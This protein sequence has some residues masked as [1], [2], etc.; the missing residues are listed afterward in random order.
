[1]KPKTIFVFGASRGIGRVFAQRMAQKG[2]SVYV[3]ARSWEPRAKLE[4]HFIKTDLSSSKN[5]HKSLDAALAQ[6][7]KVDALVFA[8]K[9]RDKDTK[10]KRRMQ[11]ELGSTKEIIEL[12][13]D[14]MKQGG[15]IVAISSNAARVVAPEQPPS[16]HAAK[17]ALEQLV[18]YY[19]LKLAPKGIRVNGV[20]PAI[21]L[22]PENRA[23]Y[24]KNK[25]IKERFAQAIALGR[26]CEAEDV[27]NVIEF[28]IGKKSSFITGQ[29]ITVDGGL[30]LMTPEALIRKM[31]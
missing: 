16:Y 22:K 18:R 1:M 12:A 31:D 20:A 11:V 30:S 10:W 17:A 19:A 6:V 5:I 14:S 27:S 8:Q 13:S 9:Y 25:K 21:T 2:H 3:F 26:M 24:A 7:K 28:L 23:Y 29:I 4:P 15:S